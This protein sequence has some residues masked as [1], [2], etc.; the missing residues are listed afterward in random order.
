VKKGHIDYCTTDLERR[1]LIRYLEIANAEQ[2]G[3]EFGLT[4]G[5]IRNKLMRI[6]RRASRKGYDPDNDVNS[7]QPEGFIID[8]MSTLYNADGEV[9]QRWIKSS[10]EAVNK[11]EAFR[12]ALDGIVRDAGKLLPVIPPQPTNTEEMLTV[13]PLGDPHIGMFAWGK[14]TLGADFDLDIA[15]RNLYAA[16]DHL[17]RTSRPT[18]FAH[19]VSLG[20]LFHADNSSNRTL[21][22][23]NALD[24]DTRWSKV[25][26][27]VLR[28]ILR[29]IHRMLEKHEKVVIDL[30]PGNHD[31]HASTMLSAFLGEYYRGQE[32]VK[33]NTCPAYRH[34]LRFGKNLIGMTH[35]DKGKVDGYAALMANEAQEAWA[36]T[37]YR[38]WLTGH[39]HHIR[40]LEIHGVLFE[41]FRT[42]A[43]KDAWHAAQG[44]ISGRDMVCD[45]Y[46]KEY[47]RI[48]RSI[49]G[50]R[51]I[52]DSLRGADQR[53]PIA[54]EGCNEKA[55]QT[56]HRQA[57]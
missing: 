19:L 6:K 5:T 8:K 1:V 33:V 10:Y 15:Q 39:V 42:L 11:L 2:V 41:T 49:V 25:V 45:T 28:L 7:I 36:Q 14:E 18:K 26:Q 17:V 47:G 32:R 53:R 46:H 22:S 37:R 34:Y 57:D 38:Y 35:G 13:Y 16:V 24:L 56:K 31:F 29:M 9:S 50:V 12:Q 44:Y 48:S 43:P 52:E 21:Q 54:G 55:K 27:V 51:Q 40:E 3:R 23:N 20:D 30:L 4:G